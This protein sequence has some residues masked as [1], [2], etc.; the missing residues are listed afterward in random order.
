MFAIS[1]APAEAFQKVTSTVLAAE[2]LAYWI[3]RPAVNAF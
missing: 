1:I 2:T 3:I